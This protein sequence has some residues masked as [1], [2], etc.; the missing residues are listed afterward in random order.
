AFASHA[1]SRTTRAAISLHDAS[2][3]QGGLIPTC[4]AT[5]ERGGYTELVASRQRPSTI[6]PFRRPVRMPTQHGGEPLNIRHVTR[7]ERARHRRRARARGGAPGPLHVPQKVCV[8]R[9]SGRGGRL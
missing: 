1:A 4:T 9:C 2:L 3:R 5:D 7:A 8:T 6:P